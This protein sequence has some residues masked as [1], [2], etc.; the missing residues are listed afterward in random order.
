VCFGLLFGAALATKISA[1]PLAAVGLVA[2]IVS[3]WPGEWTRQRAVS[4]SRAAFAST[5]RPLVLTFAVAAACFL[6]LQPYLLID[7]WGFVTGVG[8]E[9]AMS[10]GWYDFPYT[11]QY[12]GRLPYLYLGWQIAVFAMGLPLGLLGWVGLLWLLGRTRQRPSPG[13]IVLMSWPLL[14]GLT[15]G[16]AYAKFIRYS[17]PLLPFLCLAGSAMLVWGWDSMALRPRTA[18]RR[19]VLRLGMACVLALVLLFAAFYT[20]AFLHIYRETHPWIQASYWLCGH[21][22]PSSAVMTEEWDDPL[23]IRRIRETTDCP[24]DMVTLRVDMYAPDSEAKLEVLLDALQAADYI[25]LSSQRLYGPIVRLSERY[26]IS[27]LYYQELF[28]EH[29][30]FELVAAPAVYP[31]A[32]GVYLID[33][34][35]A[36]I[37]LATPRLLI[38]GRPQGCILDLGRADESFT[39]YDRPQ[40][41]VF[42]KVS[43]LGRGELHELLT[44]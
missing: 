20:T 32:G 22:A 19:R 14:Y 44:P 24:E 30:G 12:A 18:G 41:L 7:A 10:Q 34:P 27:S 5:K 35:R 16:A 23:P 1:L 40:P 28:A 31:H 39:V 2:W 25:A 43:H 4:R 13:G 9:I 42:A 3:A 11:R 6:L 17:L 8:Q 33:D 21:L 29:L 37:P 36:D 15:Q 26:P 38:A